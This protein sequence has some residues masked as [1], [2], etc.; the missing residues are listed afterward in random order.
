M[1]AVAHVSF[2]HC[3][4]LRLPGESADTVWFRHLLSVL[5]DPW[6]AHTLAEWLEWICGIQSY[7]SSLTSALNVF[8]AVQGEKKSISVEGYEKK[9]YEKTYRMCCWDAGITGHLLCLAQL[10]RNLYFGRIMSRKV[11]NQMDTLFVLSKWRTLSY[12]W[13]GQIMHTPAAVVLAKECLKYSTGYRVHST[14]N[15]PTC[16]ISA[17]NSFVLIRCVIFFAIICYF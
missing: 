5:W 1:S 17:F 6:L 2:D 10:Q 15:G 4:S 13:K 16:T 3:E 8:Y 9:I 7:T 11:K 14:V 12:C